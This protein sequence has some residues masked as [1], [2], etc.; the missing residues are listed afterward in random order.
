MGKFRLKGEELLA[1]TGKTVYKV[2]KDSKDIEDAA[3]YGSIQ[4]LANNKKAQE[5]SK[6]P[7]IFGFLLAL[8]Y[9]ADDIL[10]KPLREF[11]EY[12]DE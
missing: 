1:Q 8:G 10:N 9:S 12:I 11:F 5:N 6:M 3:S 2:H 4:K 7:T